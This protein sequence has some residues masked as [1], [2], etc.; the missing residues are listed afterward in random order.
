MKEQ[1]SWHMMVDVFKSINHITMTEGR[2]K[3]YHQPEYDPMSQ[4]S[5]KRVHEV[6]TPCRYVKPRT[7][8]KKEFYF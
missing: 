7:N 8:L 1:E 6:S 2:S 5:V 3:A 4:L